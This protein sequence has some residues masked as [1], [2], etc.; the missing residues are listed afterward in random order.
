MRQRW[1]TSSGPSSAAHAVLGQVTTRTWT[2]SRRRGRPARRRGCA[3][4]M[5]VPDGG[6]VPGVDRRRSPSRTRTTSAAAPCS[7]SRRCA[8]LRE[9]TAEAGVAV[10]LDGARLWNAHVADRRPAG[11]V[12]R[13]R[14]HRV[15]VPVE[16]PRAR[17]S[18]RC[19]SAARRGSPRR[20]CGASGTAAACARS[21]CSRP[22]GRYAL[23]HHLRA[24]GR[25]PRAR[26]AA[27]RG[28]RG[29]RRA[30]G[31][32]RREVETNI[33]VLD[34]PRRAGRRRRRSRP[35]RRRPGVLVSVLGRTTVAAGHPPRRRRR[36]RRPR[37]RG[38]GRD[39]RAGALAG[40]PGR[41]SPAV[42]GRRG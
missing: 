16:G 34:L 14:R 33:V 36:R 15:G 7:R 38:A 25:R 9:G 37:L 11:R 39:R 5:A 19:W 29:G 21:A 32:T 13:A 18:G 26:A 4:A 20:A 17:R 41:T 8:A 6:P 27:G 10:H 12:R 22:P 3:L 1:R 42:R 35:R 40:T 31:A 24:A 28:D 2:L 23:D 30:A